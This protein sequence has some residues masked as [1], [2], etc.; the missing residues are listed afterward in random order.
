M[1]VV[2]GVP[3][4]VLHH[5]V[6]QAGGGHGHV[7]LLAEAHIRQSV[8]SGGHILHAA[9]HDDLR[10]PGGDG[11]AGFDH[12][13]HAAAADHADGVGGNGNGHAGLHGRLTAGV[14][15]QTG[16]QGAA[17]HD[18]VHLVRFHTGALQGF[19]DDDGAQLGG[20]GI[21]QGAAHGTHGG[22][23]AVDQIYVSH[24]SSSSECDLS[25][26]IQKIIYLSALHFN[27]FLPFLPA[28][29]RIARHFRDSAK[30]PA[31]SSRGRRS[32]SPVW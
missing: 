32:F 10:I 31:H 24:F 9:G 16:H 6:H 22:T 5:G 12:G 3:Q 15:T 17:H 8:G 19:L 29:G 13:L 21:L 25:A 20:G 2:E 7:H 18:L 28:D 30:I 1:V 26:F 11:P 23:A 4:A 27:H 14:L